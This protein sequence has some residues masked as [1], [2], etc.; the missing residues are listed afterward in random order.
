M[1]T[2]TPLALT[3]SLVAISAFALPTAA[4]AQHSGVEIW[5]SVCGRCHTRQPPQ[6]YAAKDWRAIMDHMT[7][8]ARLTDAQRDAVLAFMQEGA[9]KLASNRE[10]GTTGATTQPGP[11]VIPAA[12]AWQ[13]E[14]AGAKETFTKLCVPC[15]GAEG[16]GNGPAAVAFNPH[17]ADFTKA[18]FWKDHPDDDSL[19]AHIR[20]GVRLMPA[21]GKQLT[22][23]E[24]NALVAYIRAL[25]GQSPRESRAP[26]SFGGPTLA[27]PR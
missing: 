19:A 7:L 17:P 9:M 21:F 20:D 13:R 15:H 5:A 1:R 2:A 8:N 23:S 11:Q 22:A 6:R 16:K 10:G 4:S 14:A 12:V 25:G 26:E 18:E 24:I 3:V 27:H